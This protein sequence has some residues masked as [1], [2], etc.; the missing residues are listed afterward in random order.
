ML[1]KAWE[2]IYFIKE[3]FIWYKL[4]ILIDVPS[5]PKITKY[6]KLVLANLARLMFPYQV[7]ERG[8]EPFM[9]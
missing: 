4:C 8:A 3:H 5:D 9:E 6:R 1:I 2:K 7:K